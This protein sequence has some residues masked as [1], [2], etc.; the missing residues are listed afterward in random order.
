MEGVLRTQGSQDISPPK[1]AAQDPLS[2]Q[3]PA[4]VP[5]PTEPAVGAVPEEATLAITEAPAAAHQKEEA[6]LP[7]GAEVNVCS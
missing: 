6:A 1:D 2:A 3:A 7:A 5:H 4:A